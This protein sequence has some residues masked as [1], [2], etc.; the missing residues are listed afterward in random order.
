MFGPLGYPEVMMILLVVLLLFGPDKLPEIAKIIGK[1]VGEFKK[2]I[3]QAKSTIEA[4]LQS[5][6]IKKELLAIKNEVNE[7]NIDESVGSVFNINKEI[8]Q[9]SESAKINN[10]KK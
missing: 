6:E 4:E 1:V 3:D 10:G 9:I 2:N 7:I 8:K 5:T